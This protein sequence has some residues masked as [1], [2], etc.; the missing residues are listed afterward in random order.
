MTFTYSRISGQLLLIALLAS[1]ASGQGPAGR[2]VDSQLSLGRGLSRSFER[3]VVMS[4]DP[5]LQAL[6]DRVA[7][8]LSRNSTSPIP[9]VAR[10]IESPEIN[11]ITLEGGHVY[12]TSGLVRAAGTEAELAW[13]IAHGIAL[14]TIKHAFLGFTLERTFLW[15][16]NGTFTRT[17][18][19]VGIGAVPPGGDALIRMSQM[20]QLNG[21]RRVLEEADTLGLEYFSKAGYDPTASVSLFQKVEAISDARPK[22]MDDQGMFLIHPPVSQ[23]I[24]RMES[25]IRKLR[26]RDRYIVTTQEFD[27]VRS[28]LSS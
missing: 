14:V 1:P 16:R 4:T 21:E 23:R 5:A 11:V 18:S 25:A 3:R 20:S 10:V 15:D 9:I 22:T 17:P 26:P 8:H 7:Q 27:D 12:V 19:L 28:R 6:V 2:P 13:A 24:K